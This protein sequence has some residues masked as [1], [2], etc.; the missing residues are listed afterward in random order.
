MLAESKDDE[1]L[2]AGRTAGHLE[3]G[4]GDAVPA[5]P[6]HGHVEAHPGA[7][8]PSPRS[9]SGA[10]RS[11]RRVMSQLPEPTD[12]AET[13]VLSSEA[14]MVI[15]HLCS[16][17]AWKASLS[18]ALTDAILAAYSSLVASFS[19]N[20][21][22]TREPTPVPASSGGSLRST[23]SV[24][25]RGSRQPAPPILATFRRAAAALFILGGHSEPVRVGCLAE[26]T[27]GTTPL[28]LQ[29]TDGVSLTQR[30]VVTALGLAPQAGDHLAEEPPEF[31]DYGDLF[32]GT[33]DLAQG[34]NDD[35]PVADGH[36]NAPTP[37]PDLPMR[38][39]GIEP[40]P[41]ARG[42]CA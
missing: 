23:G 12:P 4:A 25:F 28:P 30:V 11:L 9:P 42:G 34:L 39:H 32:V 5:N 2:F 21:T 14:V 31:P 36:V 26:W 6:D 20:T 15:R 17:P 29:V 37:G 40:A 22:R 18:S 10:G 16:S 38:A 7:G 13:T 27:R 3:G 19:N 33:N 41:S 1:P 35:Y 24:P 8:G